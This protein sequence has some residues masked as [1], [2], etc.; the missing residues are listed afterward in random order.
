MRFENPGVPFYPDQARI[1]S[2]G[3]RVMMRFMIV[4][5]FGALLAACSGSSRVDDILRPNTRPHS[6]SQYTATKG[7]LD[8]RSTP[9]AGARTTPEAEPQE[10]PKSAVRSLSEE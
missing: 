9:E 1:S 5:L 7:H 8:N 2:T 6:A 3:R 4:S 10:A